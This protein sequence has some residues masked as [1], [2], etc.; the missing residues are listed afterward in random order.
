MASADY[1]ILNGARAAKLDREWAFERAALVDRLG[2]R[3]EDLLGARRLR[4][5]A[6]KCLLVGVMVTLLYIWP[7]E[8]LAYIFSGGYPQAIFVGLFAG[9][10]V[11]ATVVTWILTAREMR[12]WG[13]DWEDQW[14]TL[15]DFSS[16]APWR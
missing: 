10:I 7:L 4:P 5:P 13:D 3:R 8:S 1:A 11:V 2:E 14:H 16:P 9:S 12:R 15:G 6:F